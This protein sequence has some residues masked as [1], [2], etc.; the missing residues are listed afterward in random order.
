MTV[1]YSGNL[2]ARF[3]VGKGE[4]RGRSCRGRFVQQLQGTKNRRTLRGPLK[5]GITN[6]EITMRKNGFD[7]IR[8]A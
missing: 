3:F 5:Q 2:L 7:V 4:H 1:Y 8:L 6:T